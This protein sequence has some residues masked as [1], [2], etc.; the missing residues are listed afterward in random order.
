[1]VVHDSSPIVPHSEVR[2]HFLVTLITVPRVSRV[3]CVRQM[4]CKVDISILS[5]LWLQKDTDNDI[6]DE[7]LICWCLHSLEY[8]LL[9]VEIHF[10]S[11]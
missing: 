11:L 6:H 5:S 10:S 7:P 9:L 3:S 4:S 1:M 2:R 8:E